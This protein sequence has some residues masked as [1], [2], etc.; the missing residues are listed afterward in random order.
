[1][2]VHVRTGWPFMMV[3]KMMCHIKCEVCHGPGHGT[4]V[5]T[6]WLCS[7]RYGVQQLGLYVPVTEPSLQLLVCDTC[8]L[9]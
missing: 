1:M 9:L 3:P 5:Q 2:H 8:S 4:E 7:S 6:G